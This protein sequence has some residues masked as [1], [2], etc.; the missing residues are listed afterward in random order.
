VII[1]TTPQIV[2][3]VLKLIKKRSK[4]TQKCTLFNFRG[5]ELGRKLNRDEILKKIS[6]KKVEIKQ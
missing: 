2:K 6:D 5:E 4:N 3:F 1:P